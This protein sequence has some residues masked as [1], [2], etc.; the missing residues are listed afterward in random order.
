MH[1]D[2]TL[3]RQVETDT[4][5]EVRLHTNALVLRLAIASGMLLSLY[6]YAS[7]AADGVHT[8]F[9]QKLSNTP[10]VL[11][12]RR[13]GGWE[14]RT[15]HF[16]VYSP[17]SSDEALLLAREMEVAWQDAADLADH[18]TSLHRQR[19]FAIDSIN[20]RVLGDS[21]AVPEDSEPNIIYFASSAQD[22]SRGRAKR[23]V[24]SAAAKAFFHLLGTDES[25]PRWVTTGLVSYVSG[26]NREH[27][28]RWAN[29]SR[30]LKPLWIR[31]MLE[32]NDGQYA[33]Q[34]F[35]AL[36]KA[37]KAN[38]TRVHAVRTR[39]E[40]VD[41]TAVLRH[42]DFDASQLTA[43]WRRNPLAGRPVAKPLYQAGTELGALQARMILLLKLAQKAELQ[44]AAE[45]KPRIVGLGAVVPDPFSEQPKK[46]TR[47]AWDAVQYQLV[48]TGRGPWATLDAD[49]RLF[50]S[51]HRDRLDSLILDAERG[52]SLV[53]RDGRMTIRAPLGPGRT[54]QA[55]LEDNPKDAT[56]PIARFEIRD[57]QKSTDEKSTTDTKA[58]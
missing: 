9:A 30:D 7:H 11:V 43:E 25:T 22:G 40:V 33:M 52:L 10:D 46:P 36:G 39:Q 47:W 58:G 55:W 20:V 26:E 37:G 45:T 13:A 18:W 2:R 27:A 23:K 41:D 15:P 12:R 57:A 49:G 31:A 3:S 35:R 48:A 51:R 34:L 29:R 1:H 17:K 32:G 53:E 16:A 44:Q 38:E 54:L 56:R 14:V 6:V 4:E 24:R 28:Q 21:Q 42:L 19:G 8:S 50:T 5:D